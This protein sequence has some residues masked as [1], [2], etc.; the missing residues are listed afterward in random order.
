MKIYGAQ[1]RTRTSTSIKTLAPEASAST[2]SATWALNIFVR[3]ALAICGVNAFLSFPQIFASCSEAIARVFNL[4]R[5]NRWRSL[6]RN[7]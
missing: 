3:V 7:W 5:N 6:C 4:A 1:E 2:N